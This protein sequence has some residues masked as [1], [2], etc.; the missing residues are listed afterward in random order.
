MHI[1]V[2]IKYS[3][4][5]LLLGIFAYFVVDVFFEQNSPSDLSNDKNIESTVPDQRT[6]DA[7]EVNKNLNMQALIDLYSS[8]LTAARTENQILKQTLASRDTGSERAALIER[9]KGVYYDTYRVNAKV[10]DIRMFWRDEDKKILGSIGNLLNMLKKYRLDV[11]FA[12]NA[13]M[14]AP[15]QYPNGLFIHEGEELTPLDTSEGVGNFYLKPNGVFLI[16]KDQYAEIINSEEFSRRS[17]ESIRFATQS[18]PLLLENG[19]IHQAFM[20]NSSNK[21]IRSGVGL[22]KESNTIIFAISNTRVNFYDFA[23]FFKSH[24]HCDDALYLDGHISK[25]YIPSLKREEVGG[26]FG[27]IIAVLN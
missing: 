22:I 15:N 21:N 18:G 11:Q 8:N 5:L 10:D 1:K 17:R 4:V 14:Y 2:W 12:T 3:L 19:V 7:P 24:L 6:P 26:S 20:Q 25:M 13:G 23:M 27:A 9:F 16:T